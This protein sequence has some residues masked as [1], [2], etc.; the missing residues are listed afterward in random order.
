M[1]IACWLSSLSPSLGEDNPVR[2]VDVTQTSG[3][4]FFHQSSPDKKYIL[5]SI[6]GGVALLDYD[7]D[8][9]LDIYFLN[10]LTVDTADEPRSAKS[11]LYRNNRDGTFTDVTDATGVGYPGWGVGTCV[12]DY[13]ANGWLD[14]YVT[15]FGP[16]RLYQNNGDGTFKERAQALGVADPRWSTGCAFGDYDNDGDL[17][18]FVANYVDFEMN[19]LPEF[20]KGPLCEYKGIAA[21]CGPRGLPG[22]GDV[23]YQNQG[24][25]TFVD[26]SQSARVHDPDGHHGLGAI[27]TDVDQDGLVD[28]FVANDSQPNFLYRNKGDGTFEELGFLSGTA[29]SQDGS[30]Q[31]S[32]GIAVGDYDRDGDLDLYVTNFS[33][34]YN[35]L[36]RH[37]QDFFYTDFS[38]ASGT[39]ESS[40]PHVGWGTEFF[41]YDNDGW[42]D[43][44]AVNGH[45]YPQVDDAPVGTR[46]AQP[47]LFYRNNRDGTFTEVA[48]EVSQAFPE[49]R[50][51]RG[52]AVGDLDNDGDLDLVINDLDGAPMVLRNDGGNQ[53]NWLRVRAE[54]S[55]KN[56]FAIGAR[57]RIVSGDLDQISEIRSGASYLSQN[58]LRLHF[59][60][61]LR[62]KV[63]W[64]EV[65][66][67][68]GGVTRVEDVTANQEVVVRFDFR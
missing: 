67:P 39:A 55:P 65:R 33:E 51:S 59:G 12:G 50:V 2:F 60:L 26:V 30:D 66:W 57:V 35:T 1:L 43:L 29:V 17:D 16:N 63:D 52:L 42:L 20:G 7:N 21:Q 54:G 32:M 34:E 40:F 5:E 23:L 46:Y 14:L 18:L 48:G 4:R 44:L 22:A 49:A 3:I 13:D 38:L 61:G 15:S 45:I 62:E 8:G 9:W 53:G 56:P 28:L 64:V 31:A 36:Y 47:K 19:D 41:D 11:L 27:W 10:S 6:S 25:G 58:D 24:E 37:D 68:E